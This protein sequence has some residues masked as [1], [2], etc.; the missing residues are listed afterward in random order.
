[1]GEEKAILDI[2]K[3]IIHLRLKGYLTVEEYLS[4]CRLKENKISQKTIHNLKK[5]KYVKHT[6]MGYTL[7]KKE[8]ATL[9]LCKSL[10]D[11]IL[12]AK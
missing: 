9:E 7:L 1:M 12:T 6:R 4:F 11:Q 2:Q 5:I 8:A 10:Y 3:V